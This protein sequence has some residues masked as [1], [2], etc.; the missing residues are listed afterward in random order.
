[1][2]A[3]PFDSSVGGGLSEYPG[4]AWE[5]R[6][7]CF[8]KRKQFSPAA[9]SRQARPSVTSRVGVACCGISGGIRAAAGP[10]ATELWDLGQRAVCKPRPY[11]HT[12]KQD[13]EK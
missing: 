2:R 5:Y 13:T 7:E 4:R 8:S 12:C 1:M 3:A 6:E 11:F 9:L 10:H